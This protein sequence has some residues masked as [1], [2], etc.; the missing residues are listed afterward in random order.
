MN[1]HHGAPSHG[2]LDSFFALLRRP[3]I[4]RVSEG[5]W[6]AGVATGLARWLGVDPL[7]VRAGFILFGIFFGMGVALY[8][9]LWLLLPSED[10]SLSI[11]KA[12]RHGDGGSIFLLVVTVLALFGGS[13]SAW[14]DEWA[15]LRILGLV[16]VGFAVW[17]VLTRHEP[18]QRPGAPMTWAPPTGTPASQPGGAEAQPGASPASSSAPGPFGAQPAPTSGAVGASVAVPRSAW[19]AAPAGED[20]AVTTPSWQGTPPAGPRQPAPTPPAMPRTTTPVLGFAAGAMILGAALVAGALTTTI[21]DRT[22]APGNHVSLGMAAAL[23]VIGAGALVAGMTGRRSGWIA[24]FAI[25]GIMATLIS[26]VSP[27]GVRQPW[28]AGEKSWSPVTVAGAGPYELGVGEMRL[29]LTGAA[30]DEDPATVQTIRAS[31]GMGE[32]RLTLPDDVAVRVESSAR[33]GGLTA[34]G[35]VEKPDGVIDGGGI[36]FQRTF[37]YGT[38]PTQLVIEAEVGLGHITIERD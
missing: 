33:L 27:I 7:V 16:A 20:T 2:G 19:A 12:L 18:G 37:D 1:E 26:S 13:G 38:G 9:V 35:S 31:V 21:A 32:L 6:F 5:K 8:L 15:G 29:D 3:G 22:G 23:A 14:R 28:Q 24:P 34:T 4:V 10:G 30:V 36:D 17:W 25:L 11:E